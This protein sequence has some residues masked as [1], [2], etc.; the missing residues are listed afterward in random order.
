MGATFGKTSSTTAT[1]GNHHSSSGG[2][3]S[4]AAGHHGHAHHKS[5]LPSDVNQANVT[6]GLRSVCAGAADRG[7]VFAAWPSGGKRW[8]LVLFAHGI[9][10]PPSFYAPHLLALAKAGYVVLAPR[11]GRKPPRGRR[12]RRGQWEGGKR[13]VDERVVA[14]RVEG[15]AMRCVVIAECE[16]VFVVKL[17]RRGAHT[18][19]VRL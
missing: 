7:V 8:P 19:G 9:G 18:G 3:H 1:H 14:D 13:F 4:S 17:R 2:H 11:V 10:R 6:T 16:Q 15:V 5:A 12:G